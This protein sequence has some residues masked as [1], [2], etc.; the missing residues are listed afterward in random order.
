MHHNRIW[1][2]FLFCILFWICLLQSRISAITY[3]VS[4]LQPHQ[5]VV[6]FSC[7]ES[8][9]AQQPHTFICAVPASPSVAVTATLTSLHNLSTDNRSA[10]V[11]QRGWMNAMFVQWF[12][13]SL[14]PQKSQSGDAPNRYTGTILFEY[15]RPI[16]QSRENIST[17]SSSGCIIKIPITAARPLIRTPSLPKLPYTYGVRIPVSDNGIV[18]ITAHQ[19][20]QLG[21]PIDR[22]PSRVYRL[23]CIDKEIPLYISNSFRPHLQDDDC[24]LFY[25]RALRGEK[26]FYTQYSY[27]NIY[28]LTWDSAIPGLRIT[29]VSGSKKTDPAS[30]ISGKQN[31]P[32]LI[33][34]EYTD[35]LHKEIDTD[36]RW[37]GDIFNVQQ[38]QQTPYT[39]SV[40]DNWYWGFIGNNQLA[41]Y[42]FEIPSPQQSNK[43]NAR[44]RI[45][46]T[47]LSSIPTTSPDHHY[48]VS[49]NNKS[50]LPHAQWDGQKDYEWITDFFPANYLNHGDNVIT[51]IPQH[52]DTISDKGAFNWLEIIYVRGYR[53]LD[54]HL[55]FSNSREHLYRTVQFNITGF[56]TDKLEVWDISTGRIF[57]NCEIIRENT[58][59]TLVLQDSITAVTHYYAQ[60]ADLRIKPEYLSLDTIQQDWSFPGGIDYILV[61]TDSLIPHCAPLVTMHRESG[62]K[63]GVVDIQDIYNRFSYGIRNPE[64]I[65][66]MLKYIYI[67]HDASPP[68]YL[69]LGGDASHD[70][71]KKNMYKNVVPTHLTRIPQWGPAA[72]D[73][74]FATVYGDDAF[75][76]L[77]VGR[78]PARNPREM[79]LMVRKTVNYL[80]HREYGYWN[81]NMILI[82]GVEHDFTRFNNEAQKQIIGPRMSVMRMDADP[83]SPYFTSGTIAAKTLVNHIN[84][85]AYAIHFTGHGGGNVWSDN[86]FFSFTDLNKLHNGQWGLAG[87]LPVIFSFT[88]L[89]GFFESCF[90]E[91]LGEEFLRN[92]IN[93]AVSFYG[94]S[95]YTKM[96][97]DIIMARTMLKNAMSQDYS[98]VGELTSMTEMMM[99]VKNGSEAVP[100]VRQYNLLGDPALPW[101]LVA[102]SLRLRLD[103]DIMHGSD[104]VKI[105]GNVSPLTNGYVRV[106]I[107]TGCDIPWEQKIITVIDTQFSTSFA[108]P[109]PVKTTQGYIRGFAWNDSMQLCGW[110]RFSKDTFSLHSVA[111]SPVQPLLQ[112]CVLV[113]FS[114][115]LQDSA[116]SGIPIVQCLYTIDDPTLPPDKIVFAP[117]SFVFCVYDTISDKWLSQSKIPLTTL[118]TSFDIQNHLILKFRTQD[119]QTESNV[120]TFPILGRPDL[121]FTRDTLSVTWNNDSLRLTGE[122]LNKGTACS[123]PFSISVLRTTSP[124]DTIA[125][126]SK[127][128]SLKPGAV[129]R[130]TA[131]LPDIQGSIVHTAFVDLNNI[132]EE[133]SEKNNSAAVKVSVSYADIKSLT[134]TLISLSAGVRIV[135]R[136]SFAQVHRL[137][138]FTDTIVEPQPLLSKS[139]WIELAGDGIKKFTLHCRPPLAQTDSCIWI[140][141]PNQ[142][143]RSSY[144]QDSLQNLA[145]FVTDDSSSSWYRCT[146]ILDT[147]AMNIYFYTNI[148]GP[149]ALGQLSDHSPPSIRVFAGGKELLFLDYAAKDKPFNIFISDSSG[150]KVPTVAV[151][152]NGTPIEKHFKSSAIESDDPMTVIC[153]AYPQKMNEIDSLTVM[154]EDRAGN[155]AIKTFAYR[156]GEELHIRFFSC[157]PNPFTASKGRLIRFAY[158]LTDIAKEVTLTIYTISGRKVWQWKNVTEQIGYQEIAWDGTTKNLRYNKSLSKQD[159]GYRIANGTYYAKLKV[160]NDHRNV[161]KIIR[162]TKLEGY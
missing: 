14:Y 46:V 99:L 63:V 104:T 18:Q 43:L 62:L 85:G 75:T 140:F 108:L 89:T 86:K 64:A 156:P 109:A 124:T 35:T 112:D 5:A 74:Y 154:A 33:A 116:I 120:F 114:I 22:I 7:D 31:D 139:A 158:L 12:S 107:G 84:A 128:D 39:D 23:F 27:T 57:N 150:I 147:S 142:K 130:F 91:S 36:I 159:K 132:I 80:R 103:K 155:S 87:R 9:S 81:D 48:S 60:A 151:L 15:D 38:T 90:Y 110:T 32:P 3:T 83:Q 42:R 134:D 119:P 105:T 76:D 44:L 58:T 121:V 70:M 66:T 106:G 113:S 16:V 51:F 37:Q 69:L 40:V 53:S 146:G 117:G 54:N 20:K 149:C 141:T 96:S 13:F 143:S 98:T 11:R 4:S 161:E 157:H 19:L 138:L 94:A 25:G 93:G 95:A 73:G 102:D 41:S 68:K 135:A 125:V 2:L 122:I 101:R 45:R 136:D 145:V 71:D 6:T 162:I 111:I 29:E 126:F 133:V 21:V 118:D 152:L 26:H 30:M 1:N 24:I 28:W 137:F 148:K 56:S 131:A 59:F 79:A 61:S 129:W 144:V 115:D 153:T 34:V 8:F 160:K 17:I 10:A 127:S 78:L 65:R 47:G 72:D 55:T 77:F 50:L 82:G 52:A 100:L 49:I 97:I 92:S 123:A 67:T 88:C